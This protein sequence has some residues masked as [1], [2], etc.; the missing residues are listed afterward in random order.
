MMKQKENE[1]SCR[2]CTAREMVMCALVIFFATAAGV[3]LTLYFSKT[4][5][6]GRKGMYISKFYVFKIS[7]RERE[8]E[9]HLQ[10][11]LWKKK[12]VNV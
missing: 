3:I 8:M 2:G 6:S 5:M 1:T 9:G 4:E 10:K 11:Y 7:E 12:T